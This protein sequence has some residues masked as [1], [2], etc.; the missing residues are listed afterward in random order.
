MLERYVLDR[1]SSSFGW[2]RRVKSTQTRVGVQAV[3]FQSALDCTIAL[4]HTLAELLVAWQDF[5]R[6]CRQFA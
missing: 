1:S 3:Q 6:R 4:P 5:S 2:I